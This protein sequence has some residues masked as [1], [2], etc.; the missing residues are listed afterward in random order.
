MAKRVMQPMH[1]EH[2]NVTPLIDV[3]MCLII[4]FLLVGQ[5]AKD[6]TAG[7][8]HIPT[9]TSG[10]PIDD[11]QGRLIVNVMARPGVVSPTS[12]DDVQIIMRNQTYKPEELARALMTEKSDAKSKGHDLQL[13]LRADR[14][15]PYEC[16]A[17]VLVACAAA[18]IRSVNFAINH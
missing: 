15:L 4:F 18:D 8:V 12:K 13:A 17:P 1:D 7:S 10:G 2:V 6:E 9:A 11:Q 3:V 5:L 16:V 14:G